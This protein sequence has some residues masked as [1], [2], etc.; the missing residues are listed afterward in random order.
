MPGQLLAGTRVLE[1]AQFVSGPYCA[2]LLAG[3]GAEVIKIEPPEGDLARQRGPFPHDNPHPERSGLFLYNNVNKLG[4]TLDLQ[5]SEGRDIFRRLASQVD[6]LIEDTPPGTMQALGLG[7]DTLKET[8]PR[9]IMTS[10][11][12][13]GQTGPY[14]NYKAY[15]LNLSHASGLGYST[16][17]DPQVVQ[18]EPLREGGLIGEYD[19]GTTAAIATLSAVYARIFS[20]TGQYIDVSKQEALLHLQRPEVALCIGDGETISR[21]DTDH[22]DALSGLYPCK[23]G[24][25]YAVFSEDHHWHA[26]VDLMGNP[27]WASDEKFSTVERRRQLTKEDT[28]PFLLP[29]FAEHT[30]DEVLHGLQQRRVPLGPIYR[31]EEVPHT[32]HM[33]ARRFFVELDH[34]EAG[35]LSYPSAVAKFSQSPVN[36]KRPAPTLG[37]HNQDI[38]GGMLGYSAGELRQLGDRG[39]I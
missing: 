23:D 2:R 30:R 5:S 14:R 28:H 8:N 27:E 9:L 10:I 39:I 26:L 17:L 35:R 3:F 38:Y 36:L 33:K 31:V 12:P 21:G 11:T 25:I 37:Q 32:E 6:I 19:C 4:I 1:Y 20:G 13:F 29:W 7:Y 24:Y 16:P 22:V 18:R 15:Y 34:P